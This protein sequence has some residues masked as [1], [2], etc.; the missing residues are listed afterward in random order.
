MAPFAQLRKHVAIGS[1]GGSVD[2]GKLCGEGFRHGWFYHYFLLKV[3]GDQ[4]TITVRELPPP[5]GLARTLP[6]RTVDLH[7]A[8]VRPR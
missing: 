1:S 4:V 8:P 3:E 2:R 5:N 6:P 7:R